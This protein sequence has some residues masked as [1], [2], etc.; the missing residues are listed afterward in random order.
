MVNIP[1]ERKL[2]IRFNSFFYFFL[3]LLREYDKI[4]K[5]SRGLIMGLYF[6]FD[7]DEAYSRKK[8]KKK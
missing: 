7:L 5:L 1:V 6:G 2:T 4:S 8:I 3:L